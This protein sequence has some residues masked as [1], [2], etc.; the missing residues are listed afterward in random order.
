MLIAKGG[1]KTK[2]FIPVFAGGLLIGG[3]PTVKGGEGFV[4]PAASVTREATTILTADVADTTAAVGAEFAIGKGPATTL[5]NRNMPMPGN[6][7]NNGYIHYYTTSG[8]RYH[9]NTNALI[10]TAI[11]IPVS[12][13]GKSK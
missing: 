13:S 8:S 12:S 4:T 5:I 10:S 2:I 7:Y 3:T 9:S 6:G 1:M 11:P